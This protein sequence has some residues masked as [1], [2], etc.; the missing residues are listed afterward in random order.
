[1]DKKTFFFILTSGILF[2]SVFSASQAK[3]DSTVANNTYNLD[4]WFDNSGHYG[5]T[6]PVVAQLLKTQLENTGYFSVTLKTTDWTTYRTQFG[7]MS[8]FL[9]G[10]WDDYP[11]ESDY[12]D[13][14]VGSGAFALGTNYSSPT[15]DNYLNTMFTSN[16]QATRTFAIINAQSLMAQDVPV[17]PL[18][19]TQ[20]QFVAYGTNIT[21]VNLEP[22]E[23]MH[24]KTFEKDLN[25]LN[26]IILGTT[27]SIASLDPANVYSFWA[28]NTLMQLSHGLMELPNSSTTAVPMLAQSYS[29]SP[30]GLTYTFNLKPNVMFSDNSPVRPEDVIWS[31]NRSASLPGSP[32]FL[33]SGIDTTSFQ[34]INSTALSFNLYSKDGTFLQKLTY[35]NAFVYKQNNAIN[36]TLQNGIY[37]PIG[38]GPYYVSSWTVNDQ[39]VLSSNG[40]Y[41]A[42]ALEVSMPSNSQVTVKFFTTSTNLITAITS[43][44]VD[45]AYHTFTQDQIVS[46]ESNSSVYTKS[47]PSIGI[48]YLVI[49]VQAVPVGIRQAI[50]YAINRYE[51]VNTIFQNTVNEL[52][53]TV[54]ENFNNGCTIYSACAFPTQDLTE[55]PLLMPGYGPTTGSTTSITS[56]SSSSDATTYV[57]TVGVGF[58]FLSGGSGS[59]SSTSSQSKT[60]INPNTDGFEYGLVMISLLVVSVIYRRRRKK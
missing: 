41:S 16:N 25:P 54:P 60:N 1:M 8:S 32:S 12:I 53:S 55:L 46:L 43:G 36:N 28:S 34:K 20:K 38:C 48:R 33:L 42:S 52:Y 39:I 29:I 40:N 37:V 35:T 10:W 31:L 19:T 9:L 4:I 18:F 14:F 6:E 5:D 7:K 49:N 59:S 13:P 24:F 57:T 15:M 11:D 3:I 51:F 2:L 58:P 22:A 21:G 17:I 50:S 23:N 30:D 56:D 45:V 27:D 47:R 44:T 26:P